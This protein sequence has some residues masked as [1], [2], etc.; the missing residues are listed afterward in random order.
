MLGVVATVFALGAL[1]QGTARRRGRRR[2]PRRIQT[3]GN[4]TCTD[5]VTVY[6]GRPGH[7]LPGLWQRKVQGY[8][9]G[10]NDE[11]PGRTRCRVADGGVHLQHHRDLVCR[12]VVPN[13]IMKSCNGT[14][15]TLTPGGCYDML[16]F[17]TFGDR[18]IYT[19]VVRVCA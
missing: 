18:T 14:V 1:A 16:G 11:R 8:T 9:L 6:T 19:P 3:F 13:N 5:P 15:Y 10:V 17:T 7:R 12:D 2:G 4:A